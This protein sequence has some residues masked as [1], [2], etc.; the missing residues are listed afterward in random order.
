MLFRC[1]FHGLVQ[2]VVS[3]G[4][5]FNVWLKLTGLGDGPAV[6]TQPHLKV[7]QTGKRQWWWDRGRAPISKL[8]AKLS[9][10]LR[11][12]LFDLPAIKF[13]PRNLLALQ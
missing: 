3:R 6:K 9:C 13:V 7:A 8:Q 4:Q 5:G 10:P 12:K 2:S 1:K 11:P